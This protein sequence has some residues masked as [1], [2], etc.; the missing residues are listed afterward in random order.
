MYSKKARLLLK[1]GK[2]KIINYKP[3]TVQ[4]IYGSSGYKQKT[5][6]GIDTCSKNVGI[7]V[8]TEEGKVLYQFELELRHD[9]HQNMGTRRTLRRSRRNRK[10][11]YR[12]PRF[13]NRRRPEGWL[14]PSLN[15]K[16]HAIVGMYDRISKLIP[17]SRAVVEIAK[18]D[19]QKLQ[20][21]NISGIQYHQGKHPNVKFNTSK[22]Y[23]EAANVTAMKN[24]IVELLKTRIS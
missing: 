4:L 16:V 19:T 14:P 2:A 21:P 24:K 13:N 11:R 15:S 9:I 12:K 7:A 22:Q 1:Q 10:T 17:I 5:V 20:N 23:K 8:V 6:L 3:F 18:F